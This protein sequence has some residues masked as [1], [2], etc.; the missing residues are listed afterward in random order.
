MLKRSSTQG[1]VEIQ[2]IHKES[3]EWTKF[4]RKFLKANAHI[5]LTH[6]ECEKPVKNK[7]P[8]SFHSNNYLY[9]RKTLLLLDVP[10]Y[11]FYAVFTHY[12][13]STDL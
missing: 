12:I 2:E 13:W 11:M 1:L 5:F 9:K 8:Q 7:I 4:E 3:S 6:I 10:V